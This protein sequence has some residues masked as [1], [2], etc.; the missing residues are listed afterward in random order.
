V[1]V[2]A[3]CALLGGVVGLLLGQS[4]AAGPARAEV[5][6]ADGV[7]VTVSPG[8]RAAGVDGSGVLAVR[9]EDASES[10]LRVRLVPA[11]PVRPPGS[12]PVRLGALQ[13]WRAAFPGVV[14]YAAP[15]TEG[16]V[17]VTCRASPGPGADALRECERT[18]S[19]LTLAASA[20]PLA[21]TLE[22]EDRLHGIVADLRA[23]RDIARR[24]L[25]R[26]DD[27][28]GQRVLAEN[29]VRSH[30]RAAVALRR[31]SGAEPIGA[32]VRR[33]AAVYASLA[34]SAESGSSRRWEGARE[35]LRRLDDALD[36]A[37]A[38]RG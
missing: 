37:L 18:A 8:W 36:E 38:A 13:A 30:E 31:L 1:V 9:Q 23:K 21:R 24:Q 11:P 15:T 27:P 4:P 5:I 35:R 28:N 32:A 33:A 22:A 17:L 12:Q 6:E 16:T 14:R 20:V 3:G 10:S 29:L 26:A 2:V 7:G 25:A 19:T 34:A